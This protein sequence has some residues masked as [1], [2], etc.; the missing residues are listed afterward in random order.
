MIRWVK[1]GKR[2][3]GMLEKHKEDFKYIGILSIIFFVF[4]NI[5]WC[6]QGSVLYDLGR[7]LYL[8]SQ[9]LQGKLL[10]KD[11]FN[12]Y[13]PFSYLVNAGFY[14]VFGETV[15]SAAFAGVL[16]AFII[17]VNL[18]L[19]GAEFFSKRLSFWVSFYLMIL[20]IFSPSAFNFILPYSYG[21]VY[22]LCSFLIS[23]LFLIKYI[24][25]PKPVFAC[26]SSFF[27]G[28]SLINKYEYFFMPF[29]MAY[30]FVFVKP[31]GRL[32][33]LKAFLS[34]ISMP[35]VFFGYLFIQGV[36]VEDLVNTFNIIQ[37]MS[38]TKTLDYFY[39]QIGVYFNLGLVYT[40]AVNFLVTGGLM[41]FAFGTF[42]LSD[43]IKQK[44][45]KSLVLTI[46]CYII[47]LLVL[48]KTNYRHV[49]CF[50]PILMSTLAIFN[51]KKLWQNKPLLVLVACGILSTLKTFYFIG[52]D[53][54]GT[55]MMPLILIGFVAFLLNLL[56]IIPKSEKKYLQIE[57]FNNYLC[58]FFLTLT[59]LTGVHN[60]WLTSNN[61][62]AVK[63]EKG[64]IY[65]V[66]DFAKSMNT[67]I[68]Y[69]QNNTKKTD[70]VLILPETPMINFLTDRPSD[71]FYNSLIP[72]YV[73][74][75]GESNII[76]HFENTK[77]EVIIFNRRNT[78]DY[79][80]PY[81]CKDYALKICDYVEEKYNLEI[82]TTGLYSHK[83][84]KRKKHEK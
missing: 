2:A 57:F 39:T 38:K 11:I 84:Y 52:V 55:Y 33:F 5:F 66:P 10:Y 20:T 71:N 41:L 14:K 34:M 72:L 26:L 82:T 21:M 76:R 54:Y 65:T 83:I 31:I 68:E 60:L 44:F 58:Y 47:L 30:V 8:P 13:G 69:V 73:E 12:I 51:I 49:F 61:T 25:D 18:Y 15:S 28:I 35:I 3:K 53:V 29:I 77:P 43:K 40:D 74:T 7:E 56:E 4:L 24:K 50:L 27:I 70:T 78:L 1:K 75:F 62:D 6:G 36:R 80:Q 67:V 42:V 16:A 59:I 32:N 19:I 17:L 45:L 46:G 37:T 23:F 79:G 48:S 81:I 64:A 22:A 9:I 63:S